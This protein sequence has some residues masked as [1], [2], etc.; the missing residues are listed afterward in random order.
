RNTGR[1]GGAPRERREKKGK[2]G[3]PAPPPAMKLGPQERWSWG[4]PTRFGDFNVSSEVPVMRERHWGLCGERR[5]A[6]PVP[7]HVT[8]QP[9]S[10]PVTLQTTTPAEARWCPKCER[11]RLQTL[12]R[13]RRHQAKRRY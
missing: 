13:V 6:N 5:L 11:R 12:E 3:Q 4:P 9:I 1:G 10:A 7:P 2:R 8:L